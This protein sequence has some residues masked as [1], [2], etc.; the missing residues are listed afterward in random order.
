M[1][2]LDKYLKAYVKQ[3]QLVPRELAAELM[4]VVEVAIDVGLE[5]AVFRKL[6][7]TDLPV[8]KYMRMLYDFLLYLD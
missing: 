1:E 3:S 7:G 6:R 5:Q 8:A 2:E 4:D